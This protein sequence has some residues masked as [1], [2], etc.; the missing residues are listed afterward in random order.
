MKNKRVLLLVLVLALSFGLIACTKSEPVEEVK[1]EE[2]T[3]TVETATETVYPLTVTD[4][5]GNEVVFE[6]A[7]E[8]VVSLSPSNTENLFAVGA[9]EKLVG[10]TDYCDYPAE[11][12]EVESIGGMTDLNYEAVLDRDPDL[13]LFSGITK[14]E[15]YKFFEDAGVNVLYLNALS[16]E[17]VYRVQEILGDVFNLS[18]NAEQV[19]TDMKTKVEEVKEKVGGEEAVTVFYE[20]WGDPLMSAG[21]GTFINEMIELANGENVVKLDEAYPNYSIEQL[22]AD[23]PSVYL[24]PNDGMMP[25]NA[26]SDDA[27]EAKMADI[28]S[29]EGYSAI[30]AIANDRIYLIDPDLTTIAGPRLVLGLE[31]IAKLIHPEAFK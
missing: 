3:S 12:L 19:I 29:R 18:G 9:G 15:D 31:E 20:V 22:I 14:E 17:D 8:R 2:G 30:S 26:T 11:A 24:A 21:K 25:E 5:S 7:P 6:K 4:L 27:I 23:D 1:G 16:F 10:R 13:V 28:K